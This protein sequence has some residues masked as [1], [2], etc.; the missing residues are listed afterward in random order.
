MHGA[1]KQFV[2][3]HSLSGGDIA[4]SLSAAYVIELSIAPAL[5]AATSD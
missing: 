4:A 2:L 1:S 3:E 5:S